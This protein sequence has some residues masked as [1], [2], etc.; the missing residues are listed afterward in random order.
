MTPHPPLTAPAMRVIGVSNAE[1]SAAFYRDVLGFEI[2]DHEAVR[3]PARVQFGAASF[4]PDDYLQS[5]ARDT[6]MLFLATSD[7]DAAHAAITER[8]GQPSAIEKVNWIK[9]RLFAVRDPDGHMV[10][11]GKSY[12]LPVPAAPPPMLEKALPEMPCAN[13]AAAVAHYRN[14]L[15]FGIN[16][17]HDDF[18]VMDRDNITILLTESEHAGRGVFEVYVRDAGALHAELRN[19]GANVLGEPVSHPWGLRDFR[20]RD[21]DGNCITFAQTFE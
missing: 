18:G 15:G 16:Y 21:L 10:W 4:A 6:A 17:Q 14:V 9:M 11:F 20:V 12:D 5:E 7:L 8:S 13:V 1:A 2:R 3:G 19:R